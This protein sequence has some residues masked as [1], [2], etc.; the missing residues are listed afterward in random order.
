[1]SRSRHQWVRWLAIML[2]LGNVAL[3]A[4]HAERRQTA[5]RQLPLHLQPLPEGTPSLE[6]LSER[7]DSS[8]IPERT[9][10][11]AAGESGKLP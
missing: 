2:V 7:R 3:Y 1:M 6:L 11:A 9:S 8:A 5:L 4:W 10:D